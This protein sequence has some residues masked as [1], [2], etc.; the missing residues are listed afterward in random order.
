M[1]LPVL[2]NLVF[3]HLNALRWWPCMYRLLLFR[4]FIKEACADVLPVIAYKPLL[5]LGYHV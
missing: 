1:V 4:F 3:E 5:N 2:L